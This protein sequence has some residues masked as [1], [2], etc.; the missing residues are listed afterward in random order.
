MAVFVLEALAVQGRPSGS[1]P[2]QEASGAT[3]A[4]CP[5]EVA[6]PLEAEHGVEDVERDHRDAVVRVCRGGRDPGREGAGLV[7]PL[8]QDLAVLV[9]PVE[10]EVVRVLGLVEL[11]DLREDSELA[12]HPLHPERPELVGDDRHNP[13]AERLV[14]NEGVEDPDER[15]RCRVLSLTAAL[16]HGRERRRRRERLRHAVARGEAAAKSCAAFE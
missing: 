7:D 2:D 14:A 9:L 12:E 5:R 1:R 15:H 4:R 16:E 11:A 6:D 3:V 13:G 8:L 10:H